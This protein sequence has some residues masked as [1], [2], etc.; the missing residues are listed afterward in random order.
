M[1]AQERAR[2]LHWRA[3]S[4]P[5]TS[6]CCCKLL[7]SMLQSMLRSLSLNPSL[8]LGSGGGVLQS[9]LETARI[10]PAPA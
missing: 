2:R 6:S 7:Q 5:G 8:R 9:Y 1:S 4:S 3:W 10:A